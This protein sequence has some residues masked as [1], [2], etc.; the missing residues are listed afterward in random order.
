MVCVLFRDGMSRSAAPR[1]GPHAHPVPETREDKMSVPE[2]TPADEA[3]R[4]SEEKYR[5][6]FETM[7]EGV[8][9]RNADGAIVSANPAALRILGLTL[10]EIIGGTPPDLPVRTVHWDGSDFPV[11]THPC[12]VA[13]RTGTTVEDVR[14]GV[15]NAREERFRWVSINAIPQFRT[16]EDKPFQVYTTFRDLTDTHR[17]EEALAESEAKYR[18]LIETAGVGV[19][20]VDLEGRLSYVNQALCDMLGRTEHELIGV[21]FA[22][23]I[24]PEDARRIAPYLAGA[25]QQNRGDRS[26]EFR[27]FHRDGHI[28]PV[29]AATSVSL[30]SGGVTGVNTVVW[31]VTG[32]KQAEQELQTSKQRFELLFNSVSDA[33]FV[34]VV[35]TVHGMPGRFIEVNDMACRRLG[36]SREELLGMQPP[37]IDAPETRALIP[38]TMEKLL[39]DHAA[40]FQ[41]VHVRKDGGQIQVEISARLIDLDGV[42][43]I[44]STVRDITERKRAEKELEESHQKLRNLAEHLMFA[45][46]EERKNVARE[47]HDELGQVLTALKMDF[48]WLEKQLP[49]S[50]ERVREKLRGMTVL[51]D[52]T[53]ER[54]QRISA[55]L[56]PRMLDDLGLTAAVEWLMGD[57]SRRTG[58]RTKTSVRITESRIGGNSASAIYR[59]IQEALTNIA[60]HAKA[61]RVTL[62]MSEAAGRLEILVG[63]DGIGISVSQASDVRSFGLIG[64]RER[65][66]GLGGDVSIRG[67]TGKGTTIA[68]SIP[69]P[70]GGNLA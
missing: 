10:D 40:V 64:I 56:R 22:D 6:L 13:L 65:V 42:P 39:H 32:L 59:I 62:T 66:R 21:P 67:E 3:L 1:A 33:V 18:S 44:F 49:T 35:D 8:I 63:D 61:S 38:A 17:M 30:P 25:R 28:V 27:I 26:L 58:I 37:D 57:F 23:L 20:T 52:Q 46:E 48:R 43:V 54:V 36:Y 19:A 4:E 60:R 51:T 5:T 29:R 70:G 7:A 34:H 47:L 14:M 11:H 15:F 45:R 24:H 2:R 53:I 31:D 69:Y 55:E 41:G 16:G 12:M 9:Y 50:P 68:I